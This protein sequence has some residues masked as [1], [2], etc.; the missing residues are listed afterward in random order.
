MADPDRGSAILAGVTAAPDRV[1]VDCD[2]GIDDAAALAT[3]AALQRRGRARL[4]LVTA[5]TGNVPAAQAAANAA[6]VLACAG[7]PRVPVMAAPVARLTPARARRIRAAA[8]GFHGPDGLGG[9]YRESVAPRGGID[10]AREL[11]RRLEMRGRG[12]RVL[13]VT[14]PCTTLDEALV[15]ADGAAVERVD[16]VVVMGGAFGAPGGNVTPWAEFNFWA[17]APAAARV[18]RAG[19][20]L[21]IVPLDVTM[22]VPFTGADVHALSDV[23]WL[24]ELVESSIRLHRDAGGGARCYLHDAVAALL[25]FEPRLARWEERGVG[26]VAGGTKVGHIRREAGAGT[27]AVALGID[28][29]GVRTALLAL[30]AE[31]PTYTTGSR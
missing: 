24:A 17:D 12:R 23:G 26:V 18:C 9:H 27:A 22:R 7:L 31:A 1:L 4:E 25:A 2:G 20:P 5:C 11:A 19:L 3:V 14:G 6:F 15:L 30:W 28:A 21:R 10:G 8:A 16:E 29:E 13:L